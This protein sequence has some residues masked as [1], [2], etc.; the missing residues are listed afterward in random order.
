MQS[1]LK[2]VFPH[3]RI[4]TDASERQRFGQDWTRFYQPNPLAIVFPKT[5]DDVQ[6]LVRFA[7]QNHLSI[8]P[9]GGRTGLSGGA[10]ATN[11]E[12]VLAMD[13]MNAILSF[14]SVDRIV[15]VQAGVLTETIQTYAEQ[16]GLFYPVDFASAGSNQ[17]GGNIAT[18][19]GGI[20]VIRYGMTREWVVGLKV[21]TGTGEILELNHGLTKNNTGYD[22]RHLLIGSEGTL[23]IICE[24]SLRLTTRPKTSAVLV[25]GIPELNALMKVLA[26][27]QETLTLSAFE[28]F[29]ELALSEVIEHHSIKRPFSEVT[30]YYALIE[31]E[32][33]S[34][35]AEQEILS[36]FED[37]LEGHL[38]LDGCMSQSR[39]QAESLWQ[40]R[41]L[42]SETISRYLPYKNDISVKVSQVPL[43]LADVDALITAEYPEFKIVW[44][45][46]IGDGNVHL[47]ILKP[48]DWSI[49]AFKS[50]CDQVSPR[51]FE[52]VSKYQGSV[53]A[54]HGIGLLKK[55]F[56]QY[57]RSPLE[58][59]IMRSI[60]HAF[61]P[62]G[63][64]NP[65]KIFDR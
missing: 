16:H 39:A 58:I 38:A 10:V 55:A 7:I 22:L 3:L 18:N 46:H 4:E 12:I 2:D 52:L 15:N 53:S 64:L 17:I 51:I 54:E 28:F 61:D 6:R 48:E 11:G 24:A 5:I 40:C 34:A 13:A 63:I 26:R 56:L 14:D 21:V 27:F 41:E 37:C 42:I 35:E 32:N 44:F 49:D 8:V 47:N 65:G 59:D 29:S 57:S 25:L 45:G 50:K 23:G 1:Q 9:S 43:F 60:R 30:P 19:A 31:C 36:A 33:S 20:N 62:H